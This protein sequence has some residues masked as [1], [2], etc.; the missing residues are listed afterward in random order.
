M[1]SEFKGLSCND[2]YLFERLKS[3]NGD[4]KQKDL[5]KIINDNLEKIEK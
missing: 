3:N 5:D 4:K 1:N 2:I